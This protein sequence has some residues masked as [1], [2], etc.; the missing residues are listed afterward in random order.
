MAV[1]TYWLLD[2]ALSPPLWIIYTLISLRICSPLCELM[3]F[4]VLVQQTEASARRIVEILDAPSDVVLPP[5]PELPRQ[6]LRYAM[7]TSVI[8]IKMDKTIL[9]CLPLLLFPLSPY[10]NDLWLPLSAKRVP[11]KQH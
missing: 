7:F 5:V 1:G 6:I 2:G 9:V 10:R 3:D 4:S 8:S 11:A